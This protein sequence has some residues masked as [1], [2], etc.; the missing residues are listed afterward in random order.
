ML[1]LRHISRPL[2]NRRRSVRSC[3]AAA[4]GPVCLALGVGGLAML[5][6]PALATTYTWTG[7]GPT[8]NWNASQFVLPNFVT[9]WG[10]G[11]SL[12]LP[13]SSPTTDIVFNTSGVSVNENIADPFDV[14][15][16]TFGSSAGP[17]T[18]KGGQLRFNTDA[19]QPGAILQNSNAAQTI[20]ELITSSG[21]LTLGGTGAGPVTIDAVMSGTGGIVKSG[22]WA[23]KLGAANTL[24]GTTTIGGGSIIVGNTLALQN[25]TV[26]MGLDNGLNLNGLPAATLGGLSGSGALNLGNTMLTIG[27]NNATGLV[28]NGRL[29]GTGGLVKAGTGDLTLSGPTSNTFSGLTTVTAG[30]LNLSTPDGVTAIGGDLTTNGGAVNI[31]GDELS[32][33]A[34]VTVN[35]GLVNAPAG[36]TAGKLVYDGGG[37]EAGPSLT[38]TAASQYAFVTGVPASWTVTPINL[39]GASGGGMQL[40]ATTI[41]AP[42]NLGGALRE[43]SAIS[44]LSRFS[45]TLS[46]GGI[47]KT[48]LG[49]LQIGAPGINSTMLLLH[50]DQGPLILDGGTMSL[51]ST[52]ATGINGSSSLYVQNASAP[53]TIRNGFQLNTVATPIIDNDGMLTVDGA[54]TSWVNSDVGGVPASISIGSSGGTSVLIVQ[55]GATVS[56][57]RIFLGS[58]LAPGVGSLLITSGGSVTVPAIL[59]IAS[60]ASSVTVDRATLAVGAIQTGAGPISVKISD[61]AAPALTIGG[62]SLSNWDLDAVVSDGKNGPGSLVKVGPDTVNITSQQAYTGSTTIA[63]GTLRIGVAAGNALAST[64]AVNISG[65]GA[66]LDLHGHNLMIASLNGVAGSAVTLGSSALVVGDLTTD[67]NFA[68]TLSGTGGLVK[69]NFGTQTLSGTGSSFGS[70]DV[71]QGPLILDGGSL[72]LSSTGATGFGG[73]SSLFV[74]GRAGDN[75]SVTVRNGFQLNTAATPSVHNG[76]VITVDGAGTSW[77]NA[78]APGFPGQIRIGLAGGTS[79]LN[80]QN[81]AAVTS[82][83]MLLGNS[84]PPNPGSGKLVITSGGSVA[85]PSLLQIYDS[86]SSITVD[87]GTLSVGAL[88]ANDLLT[89]VKISDGATAALTLAGGYTGGWLLNPIISDGP[90]GPGSVVKNGS[91]FVYVANQNTYTGPTIVNAGVLVLYSPGGPAISGNLTINGGSAYVPYSGQVKPTANIVVN[92][93]TLQFYAGAG[94]TLSFTPATLTLKSNLQVDPGMVDLG[95]ARIVGSPTYAAGLSEGNVPGYANWNQPNN[96]SGGRQLSPRMGETTAGWNQFT[97][98]V[99]TGQIYDADGTLSLGAFIDDGES[100]KI[101]GVTRLLDGV[102]TTAD[103]TG[104]LHLGMGPKGDG[105]HD[106]DIRFSNNSGLG[107]ASSIPGVAGWSTTH[108][109]GLNSAGTTSTDGADYPIP[110]D[111]GSM[112]LFRTAVPGQNGTVL[113][114][115][116]ASLIAGGM[117]NVNVLSLNGSSVSS[118]TFTLRDSPVP[119]SDDVAT[120]TL[121]GTQGGLNIGYNHTFTVGSLSVTA[122]S[123]LD[124]NGPG[125]LTITSKPLLTADTVVAM[126][127]GTLNLSAGGSFGLSVDSPAT[128]NA[129]GDSTFYNLS[130]AGSLNIG[131]N[132][133]QLLNGAATEFSGPIAGAGMLHIMPSSAPLTLSGHSPFAGDVIVDAASLFLRGS[134]NPSSIQANDGAAVTIDGATINLGFGTLATSGTGTVTYNNATIVGGFIDGTGHQL[135]GPLTLRGSTLTPAAV[136]SLDKLST[137]TNTTNGGLLTIN[138]A[139]TWS[140]ANSGAGHVIVKNAL[141][142]SSFQNAGIIDISATGTFAN[143]NVNLVSSGGSQIGI[144]PGGRLQLN[145]GK[146]LELNGALLT[147]NGTITGTTNVNFG[148]LATGAGAFGTV[149]V[150]NG[151]IF[152]PSGPAMVTATALNLAGGPA[153][154]QPSAKLIDVGGLAISGGSTFDMASADFVLRYSGTSPYST[155]RQWISSGTIFTS[156][157]CPM[158]STPA[159]LAPVDNQELHLL[160]WHGDTLSDGSDFHQLLLACT[161]AGDVNLDGVVNQLDYVN[162][163]ANMGKHNASWFDGDVNLDGFVT[164]DDFNIVTENLGSGT[165][166]LAG[167]ALPAVLGAAVAVPEPSS[168]IT[169]LGMSALAMTRHRVRRAASGPV[170]GGRRLR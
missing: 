157:I 37:L 51:F 105:W 65:N 46:N 138:A 152:S 133:V 52:G 98:W 35:G 160:T 14:N 25:S 109:F 132:T 17:F 139:T 43:V 116:G 136:I 119:I 131:F 158:T 169:L 1:K 115:L 36:L 79:I 94:N 62:G 18:L 155:Y 167:P 142:T 19:G 72:S 85:V 66:T 47:L 55:N 100:V 137:L 102:W 48:G 23:L 33:N 56:S 83:G 49:T 76:G 3:V 61:G 6:H 40:T 86:K 71:E 29:T 144:A 9:N 122:S 147:N 50:A 70:I 126:H 53:L 75:A 80:V 162:I 96:G 13:I 41:D 104:V 88:Q 111:N 44:G 130:G 2:H 140:G 34:T 60:S 112:N 27:G 170:V 166:G 81:N 38:L 7:Q 103:T 153:M 73:T 97:T 57:T 24:S 20:S 120:L 30:T 163:V 101:D 82:P 91:D 58:L 106:I 5:G 15:T 165:G 92:G 45:Q 68:G 84:F 93:G 39:T 16:L 21:N 113:V 8:A 149:N 154:A 168:L 141:Q 145:G 90:S 78:D 123:K 151:G 12:I 31:A 10:S 143:S 134:M 22:P 164:V 87:H 108:G 74:A 99:Y 26:A 114:G 42:I 125:S 148:S 121:P 135:I 150:H 11:L 64:T 28:Y 4:V 128:V 107:G 54:G 127:G 118:A 89:S 59:S 67:K 124:V 77:V 95:T 110:V 146:T 129:L 63:G 156:F 69:V 32:H 117:S 159:V 161:Y